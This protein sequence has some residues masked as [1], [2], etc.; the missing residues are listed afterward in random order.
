MSELKDMFHKV[1]NCH[2]KISVCAGLTKVE[3]K[4][5]IKEGKSSPE[6]EKVVE[7]L[8]TLEHYA[9][10][11]GKLLDELKDYVFN[12]IDSDTDKTMRGIG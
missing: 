3:L 5:Y 10:E 4:D 1:G 8:N 2:N 6:L 11:A 9:I 12:I 7:R